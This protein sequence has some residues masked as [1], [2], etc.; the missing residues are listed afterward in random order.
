VQAGIKHYRIRYLTTSI[1]LCV[2]GR[3]VGSIFFFLFFYIYILEC[4]LLFINWTCCCY[5]WCFN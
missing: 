4:M 2:R 1:V 5:Y 3:R